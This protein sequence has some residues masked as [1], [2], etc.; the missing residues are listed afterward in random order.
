MTTS[1]P[2][3]AGQYLQGYPQL[4]QDE[5]ATR[6]QEG[7]EGDDENWWCDTCG[8]VLVAEY[9]GARAAIEARGMPLHMA[10]CKCSNIERQARRDRDAT[11]VSTG[12]PASRNT[13]SNFQPRPGTE[14]AFKTC[15]LYADEKL[16]PVLVLL[17]SVGTGKTHLAEAVAGQM[18]SYGNVV[19]YVQ[20]SA[21][22]N[23]M[24]AT[25]K[26]NDLHLSDYVHDLKISRLLIIDDLGVGAPPEWAQG[27][28][29]DLIDDRIQQNRRLLITTNL[30]TYEAA[31]QKLGTR[32]ADRLYD[33]TSGTVGQVLMNC[34]SY[35]HWR[36]ASG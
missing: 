6:I 9:P 20:A 32:I 31:E 3:R 35:R 12:L 21:L 18:M 23:A 7:G 11:F 19:R 25:M 33:V 5:P 22:L 17:G 16:S 4:F 29:G 1:Q 34:E 27:Q 30:M 26:S 28:I 36:G 15:R 10:Q 14:E 8:Y 13:F 2:R 24:Y